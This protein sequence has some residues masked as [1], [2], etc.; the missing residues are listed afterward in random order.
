MGWRSATQEEPQLLIEDHA[1][2]G[3]LHTAALVARD[4]SI[5]F[6]CLPEFDSDACF[7]SLLGR[8]E[9]GRWKIAPTQTV[10]DVRRQ[11]RGDTMILETEFS[12]DG[13][14]VRLVDFMPPRSGAP[15][16][17]RWVEGV[18]GK[19][20]VRFELRPRFGS[21]ITIPRLTMVEDTSAAIAGGDAL[22]LQGG[23]GL[24]GVP[25]ET[26]LTVEAGQRIPFVLSWA[27][28]YEAAPEAIDPDEAL[29]E[30]EAH[31]ENWVKQLRLP[32]DYR[33]V[34][35]RS[36]LTLKACTYRPSGAIVAA[37]TF[38]LPETVGGERN[39]DYRFCWI[40]D[41][42]L[43]LNAL[44]NAGLTD[45][46]V[47]F[48]N[49]LERAIGGT[50][51]QLQ[52]MYGIRGERRLTE[53]VLPWL[54]GYEGSKP[55]RIGNGAYDQF[56]LDVLGEFAMVLFTKLQ[57]TGE[58]SRRARGAFE[59][60]IRQTAEAWR[61]PDHGIWE[62]RGPKR[63]FTAS[64]VSAW[65]VMDRWIRTIDKFGLK[66]DKR[67]WVALRDEI[68]EEVCEK[69]YDRESNSFTQY[70]GSKEL[71]GSLL[72][73]PL[74]GFL[75]ADDPRVVGTV[76]RIEQ[77]LVQDGLVLRY[78]TGAT[79]DGLAGEE[80]TFLACSF[81]LVLTYHQMGRTEEARALFERL[82]ALE[83][84]VGLL[85]EEY[86]PRLHRQVGN[87]PQAFSH[88]ALVNAAYTLA[89][90]VGH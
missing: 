50:A 42:S 1:L 89:P 48:G 41:A 7:A 10:T 37:P 80:G 9:N 46:A 56:Q 82:I 64:K 47:S 84:D 34:V 23:E 18:E 8:P 78:R 20:T 74:S 79:D 69:G 60:L 36:L 73:I 16:L 39:W 26:E 68:F 90:P 2:I 3:D 54:E 86:F 38:G 11:Y 71:D 14:V 40:R 83:N 24:G 13:G 87:F 33:E 85:A 31:W 67:K 15:H 65:T 4:G 51:S 61:K 52:I 19:V 28:S 75:P 66:V 12:V 30:T 53:V 58:L 49:W 88:L 6:L 22:Y 17:V 32:S 44:M 35:L 55:V 81:W 62:M 45:E 27:P 5:D 25:F 70:Y 72:F 63:H 77:D 76:R 43:T 21:G 29:S 57:M 59:M